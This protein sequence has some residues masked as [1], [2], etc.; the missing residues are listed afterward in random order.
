MSTGYS[1]ALPRNWP[2]G[3]SRRVAKLMDRPTVVALALCCGVPTL[4]RTAPAEAFAARDKLVHWRKSFGK[5]LPEG[6]NVRRLAGSGRVVAV[7][8]G[9]AAGV[10]HVLWRARRLLG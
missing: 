4:A 6:L 1:I 3:P 5:A 2:T 10:G 9:K 7:Q 8:D